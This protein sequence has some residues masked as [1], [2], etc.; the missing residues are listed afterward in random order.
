LDRFNAG[1]KRKTKMKTR[2]EKPNLKEYGM[3]NMKQYKKALDRIE[4]LEERVEWLMARM[5]CLLTVF[6]KVDARGKKLE[7]FHNSQIENLTTIPSTNFKF[8]EFD[9]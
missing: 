5:G 8:S 1:G 6:N 3:I 7:D 4:L 2:I 9:N